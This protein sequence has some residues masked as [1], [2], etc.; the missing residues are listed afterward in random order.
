M[1]ITSLLT[2]THGCEY[3]CAF[4]WMVA[5][6]DR[7]S[8]G[9]GFIYKMQR[10]YFRQ[11]SNYKGIAHRRIRLPLPGVVPKGVSYR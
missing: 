5:T 8:L 10:L 3:T 7:N 11:A 4:T 1:V 6:L 9:S 2:G